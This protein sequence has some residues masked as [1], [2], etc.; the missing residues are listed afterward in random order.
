MAKDRKIDV[1]I[2]GLLA[3]EDLTGYDIKKQ[4]DGAISFFWKGSFGSIYP[5]LGEMEKQGLVKR[6]K[7]DKSSGREKIVYQITK[8][9]KETLKAWLNDEKAINDL[10][11]ETLLKMYFG[12]IQDRSV[13]IRNIEI[14]EQQVKENL[15]V[16]KFYKGNL[17]KVLD[18]EDHV[19]YYL[20]VLFGIETY[21]AYLKWCNK[22]KKIMKE[23]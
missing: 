18:K 4:I 15:E 22:A 10:K 9:G 23:K 12:G 5:A 8:D 20:T 19:H 13:T 1:V 6:K 14:F 17:E 7:S 21:E 3:H 16:L 2:L 11:Y